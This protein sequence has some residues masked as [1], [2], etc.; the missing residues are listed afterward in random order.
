MSTTR[1]RYSDCLPPAW[2][3]VAETTA[4]Y[5]RDTGLSERH[6][7]CIW[8][9][10]KL[11]PAGLTDV[12]GETIE[13]ITPGRWNLEAGPDFLDAVLLAGPE[14]RRLAG[15]V[16][17][18]IHPAAWKQHHHGGDP[19]YDRVIA[20]VTYAPGPSA[21]DG[22]PAHVLRL[23]LRDRLRLNPGFSFDDI[24]LVA[25]PHA[26]IPATP[27]PCA[28]ALGPDPDRWTA[29]LDSA[30]LHR[31]ACK[32]A[33]MLAQIAQTRDPRQSFYEA[34]LA[35]LG[36]KLNTQAFRRL[37]QLLP[38]ADWP[39]EA[40][41]MLHY[42]RLLRAAGLLPDPAKGRDAASRTLIRQ[43][44]DLAWRH[45]APDPDPPLR[46]RMGAMRPANHPTRRLAV[47]AAVFGSTAAIDTLW[48]DIPFD[49]P[50][51]WFKTVIRRLA[52]RATPE[53]WGDRETLTQS[54]C[55][56]RPTA[57]LGATTAATIVTNVIV[58]F[59]AGT[60]DDMDGLLRALPA[61]AIDAPMR[62]TAAHLFG[63]DHNPAVY[64]SHGLR[65]QGLLQIFNDFCLNA[66]AGC[67]NCGL[68]E[69]LHT[70]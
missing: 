19:N 61:E 26:V 21:D 67:A 15:D 45:P 43:L 40:P 10:D 9:D 16:E 20:H 63:R 55:G 41:P 49:P 2:R 62:A 8:S 7:Q 56:T 12:R 66:H 58:P 22:L 25:Y 11:R 38:L 42:A 4:V 44:W 35:A 27:R 33:R 53:F 52:Q 51:R 54:T 3:T 28:L 47:A 39:R 57:L 69:S 59:L 36:Y 68:A 23:S 48:V 17:I 70:S 65:Q 50:D 46:W 14:K 37:A 60:R 64:A 5:A 34:F 30:G 18:H 13:V 32:Q 1:I 24:D 31:L 6:L 29:L